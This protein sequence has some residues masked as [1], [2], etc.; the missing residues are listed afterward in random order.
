MR[1]RADSSVSLGELFSRAVA[2]LARSVELDRAELVVLEGADTVRAVSWTPAGEGPP[3]ETVDPRDA[4]SPG[5]WPAL[6]DNSSLLSLGAERLDRAHAADGRLLDSGARSLLLAPLRMEGR[7]LG[8]LILAHRRDGAFDTAQVES[9]LPVVELLGV[10]VERSLAWNAE[11][12][13]QR[14]REKLE[15]LLPTIAASLDV[16]RV[17]PAL[18]DVIQEIVPHDVLAFALLAP[19][20][21]S[22]RVQ[23]A[24]QR[25]VLE[26]PEYRFSND[27]EA[28][29]ANWRFLLAYDLTPL[30]ESSVRARISPAGT[31]EL[32]EVVVRPGP[33]W[34]RFV[35]EA[36]VRSTLRVPIRA[37]DHPIGGVAFMSRRCD[38][39]DEEDGVLAS[40]IADHVALALAHQEL[41][42]EERRIALA[43]ERARALEQRV[44]LLSRELE[45]FSAHRA[46]GSSPRWKKALADAAQVSATDTTVLVTGESGTGKEVIARYVH[47]GSRRAKG[48]FVALNCAALPEQLLESEL[49]GHERGAFTGAVDA[50]AGRIEQAAGGT[51]FL[52]EVGEM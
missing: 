21:R 38:A 1:D 14:R 22:V 40:R 41:A 13:R 24:T 12:V 31:P 32:L 4:Y 34:I 37:K 2:V 28:L 19:D 7:T 26:L 10:V 5:L 45:R 3:V 46:L 16:R 51:L 18:S 30:D 49:F 25:G 27:E 35:R 23:A 29:D 20:R 52:D 42:E 33:A 48:P 17:F 11:A 36:G 47:R 8:A 44:D 15:T 39:Y 50:R 6:D 43:E 9:I